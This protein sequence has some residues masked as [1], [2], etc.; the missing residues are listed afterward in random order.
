MNVR[1]SNIRTMILDDQEELAKGCIKTF[2]CAVTKHDGTIISLNPSIERFLKN[3]AIQFAKMKTAITYFVFDSEDDALLGFFTLTHK[4]L[5]IP[6][7]GLSRKIKDKIKRFSPL[8][9]ERNTYT[10]SA[11]LLA[12]FSKNYQVGNGRRISGSDLMSLAKEQLL[13]AQNV[14][15]G[16]LVYLDCEADAKL[17]NFYERENFTLFGERVSE[18]DGKHYLQYLSFI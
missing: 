12:Q 3:N 17:I 2:S 4:S 10:M 15:G 8:D 16:T 9:K 7:D 14:V 5:D 11:F 1:V 18:S 13:S 6:A